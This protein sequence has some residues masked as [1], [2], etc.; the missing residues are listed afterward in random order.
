[1]DDGEERHFFIVTLPENVHLIEHES[2]IFVIPRAKGDHQG[3]FGQSNVWYA[4]A[5]KDQ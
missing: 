5:E 3:G 1:M 4:K 2:R